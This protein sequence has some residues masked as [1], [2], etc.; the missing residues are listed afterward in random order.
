[1]RLKDLDCYLR[2]SKSFTPEAR[3]HFVDSYMATGKV[4]RWQGGKGANAAATA[5]GQNSHIGTQA[6]G[7]GFM[8]HPLTA[9]SNS[10]KIR[11]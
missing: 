2:H 9:I 8:C 1:M 4:A 10:I 11:A 5:P 7:A 6:T 3:Q